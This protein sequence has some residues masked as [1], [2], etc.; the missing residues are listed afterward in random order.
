MLLHKRNIKERKK[1]KKTTHMGGFT[2][3]KVTS[4]DLSGFELW[5]QRWFRYAM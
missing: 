5:Q 1:Q 2:P 3:L 4:L